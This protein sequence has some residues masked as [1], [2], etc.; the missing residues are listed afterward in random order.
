M[1][2]S[3]DSVDSSEDAGPLAERVL[4]ALRGRSGNWL[5]TAARLPK[6]YGSYVLTGK[7]RKLGPEFMGRIAEALGV[8][9]RWLSTGEGPMVEGTPST[10]PKVGTFLMKLDRL[11]G[12]REWVEANPSKLTV[13]EV[14]AGMALYDETKPSSRSDGQ[15]MGGW[16]AFFADALAGRLVGPKKRGDQAAAEALELSQLPASTKKRLKRP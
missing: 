15:P 7:R 5:E 14:A 8:S 12:L 2:L 1:S 11:P 3:N 6:G 16:D 4:L 10:D 13:T 9:H